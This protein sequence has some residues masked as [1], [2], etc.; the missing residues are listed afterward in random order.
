MSN[1]AGIQLDVKIVEA[2]IEELTKRIHLLCEGMVDTNWEV[3][4]A[5]VQTPEHVRGNLFKKIV[6]VSCIHS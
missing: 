5:Y 6:S 1:V 2:V 3:A 4:I